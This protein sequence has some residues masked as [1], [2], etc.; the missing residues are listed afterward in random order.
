MS[1]E[2]SEL[3]MAQVV[4]M[5][6]EGES[7]QKD[8][9]IAIVDSWYAAKN[10]DSEKLENLLELQRRLNDWFRKKWGQWVTERAR[11]PRLH[12][13][14]VSRKLPSERDSELIADIN[15]WYLL[16]TRYRDDRVLVRQ[17][18]MEGSP[19]RVE[20]NPPKEIR[21]ITEHGIRR[22]NI[23]YETQPDG[24]L[25]LLA[26]YVVVIAS[27]ENLRRYV[28][29]PIQSAHE[30]V[31]L[32]S[33]PVEWAELNMSD[34]VE[35]LTKGKSGHKQPAVATVDM[36]YVTKDSNKIRE[37]GGRLADWYVE[38][39]HQWVGAT[40]K[41]P[42]ETYLL[43]S[44]KLPDER[45]LEL[46]TDIS[47]RYFIQTRYFNWHIVFQ[48]PPAD[49]IPCR[50][51]CTPPKNPEDRK[52]LAK[53]LQDANIE[54]ESEPNGRLTLLLKCV[55]V[56]VSKE[57]LDELNVPLTPLPLRSAEEFIDLDLKE[58]K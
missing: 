26:K 27:V 56:L 55:I 18:P 12:Y 14:L 47:T 49:G 13:I 32:E 44:H 39:W 24:K 43:V 20:S 2:N 23:D 29:Q 38:K 7:G 36:W 25:I 17:P 51:G 48:P 52:I 1:K 57:T 21:E 50:L 3:N 58:E 33:S 15:T 4:Q 11:M 40:E 41:S 54:Y 53:Q 5:L 28:I 30:I 37:L 46:M 19:C 45:A 42:T 35:M 22:A 6:T 31:D 10:T 9:A 16:P 34:V 8:A